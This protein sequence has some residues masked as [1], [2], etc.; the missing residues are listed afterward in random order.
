MQTSDNSIERHVIT[1]AI[2]RERALTCHHLRPVCHSK[3]V[4][5]PA[6]TILP[7]IPAPSKRPK[8]VRRNSETTSWSRGESRSEGAF[9]N[10]RNRI[11]LISRGLHTEAARL[12]ISFFTSRRIWVRVAQSGPGADGQILVQTPLLGTGEARLGGVV[13]DVEAEDRR[14]CPKTYACHSCTS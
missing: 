14:I 9:V 12:H 7:L 5:S 10:E 3:L 11:A 8:T 4:F 1:G 2:E 13:R 6:L